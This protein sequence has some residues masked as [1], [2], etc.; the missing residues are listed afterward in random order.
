[1]LVGAGTLVGGTVWSEFQKIA[2][3]VQILKFKGRTAAVV[4][5]NGT[6]CSEIGEHINTV[7]PWSDTAMA[8]LIGYNKETRH[9]IAKI[10]ADHRKSFNVGNF[11][12]YHWG[13]RANGSAHAASVQITADVVIKDGE[14]FFN[15]T[16]EEL[17][18][19]ELVSDEES[20]MI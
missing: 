10:Y 5:Y 16:D 19:A 18:A 9:V 11:C 13:E 15:E 3:D 8:V 17:T 2:R 12:E 7:P 6:M 14:L 1:M 20:S 4:N